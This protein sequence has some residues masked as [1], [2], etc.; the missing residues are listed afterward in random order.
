MSRVP[1]HLPFGTNLS[2]ACLEAA[3]DW[4]LEQLRNSLW[5]QI[6]DYEDKIKKSRQSVVKL[7]FELDLDEAKICMAQLQKELTRRKKRRP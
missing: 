4:E 7:T 6:E 3:S 5:N 1:P 2:E